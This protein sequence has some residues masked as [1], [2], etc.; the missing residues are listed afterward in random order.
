EAGASVGCVLQRS[1]G[2]TV[3]QAIPWPVKFGIKL[4][5]GAA[6]IDYRVLKRTGLVE[7]GRMED[8]DFAREILD[9]HVLGPCRQLGCTPAGMLLE[10]GPGDS[11]ATGVLGRAAGFDVV[12][13]VDAGPFADLRPAAL[14]RLFASLGATPPELAA[15]ATPQAVLD[16]LRRL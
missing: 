13:L 5:L 14:T 9:L 16:Q 4:L 8:A 12:T 7:H 2:Y 10:I 3:K 15:D 6:R 1:A 11:V